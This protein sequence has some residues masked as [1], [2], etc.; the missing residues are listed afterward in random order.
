MP[1]P[2]ELARFA[3]KAGEP[4][5]QV[6]PADVKSFWALGQGVCAIGLGIIEAACKPGAN[7]PAVVHRASQI[8]ILAHV[9][10]DLFAPWTKE[11]QLDDSVF[12][13]AAEVPMEWIGEGVRHGLPFDVED[14]MRRVQEG[15]IAEGRGQ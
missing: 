1:I 9:A 15:G 4:V 2:P 13:A 8:A 7:I 5:P 14:F 3:G 10:P 11:G 6:D 12:R